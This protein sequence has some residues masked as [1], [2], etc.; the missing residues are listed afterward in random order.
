[1]GVGRNGAA[2]KRILRRR[3]FFQSAGELLPQMIS[4]V[5]FSFAACAAQRAGRDAGATWMTVSGGVLRNA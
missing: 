2:L 1:M 3:G 5:P 4:G